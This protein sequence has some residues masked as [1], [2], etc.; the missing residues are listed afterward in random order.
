[1]TE[2][3]DF[4]I[5]NI[6]RDPSGVEVSIATV[7]QAEGGVRTSNNLMMVDGIGVFRGNMSIPEL[8][9][10]EIQI[11]TSGVSAAFENEQS[12]NANGYFRDQNTRVISSAT[13][14]QQ[15]IVRSYRISLIDQS[16]T[17]GGQT[18]S[19]VDII[20]GGGWGESY[21]GSS[22]YSRTSFEYDKVAFE[23]VG[24]GIEFSS[25]IEFY[26]PQYE[27]EKGLDVRTDFRK[28]I[29]W[30]PSVQTDENGTAIIQYYN[31]DE[32]TTFRAI[33]EGGTSKGLLGRVEHTYGVERPFSLSTRI[34][35]VLS[36]W[37]TLEMPILL[38]NTSNQDIEGVLSI[39][40]PKALSLLGALPTSIQVLK[41]SSKVIYVK[42]L[43]NNKT[44][45]D[46][47]K[48]TFKSKGLTDVVIQPIE[49]ISK[50]FP[51]SFTLSGNEK[52]VQDTFI[53]PPYH[54]GS[55]D[56]E[57]KIYSTILDDL[58]GGAEGILRS[59]WG[60]FEQ[61]S[62]AN[63]PNILA[64][65]ILKEKGT[66]RPEI[67]NKASKYLKIGYEK[68]K[69]Y[70]I[71]TGGFEWY[72]IAPAHEGLTAYGLVQLKDMQTVYADFNPAILKRTEAFLLSRRNGKGGFYHN[73]GKYGF[74]G[75][76]TALF[77]AYITWALSEVGTK[78]IELEV[79]KSVREAVKSEDL[80]R[81]SL[82]CLTL[83]NLNENARAELLLKEI[84][85]Q[86]KTVGI[87]NV[88]AESTVTYSYGNSLNIETLSFA[89]LAM[90]E[91]ST[92]DRGL[93]DSIQKYIIS[94]RKYGRFG[95]TQSTVMALKMLLKY[96]GIYART[97]A[98]GHFKVYI[99]EVLAQEYSYK[100][101][102][103]A[104]HLF[105]GFNSYF[106]L[107]KNTLRIETE[108]SI[109]PSSFELKW[110]G[111]E[112]KSNLEAPLAVKTTLQDSIT[113]VGEVI[114]MKVILTNLEDKT[115]AS[116]MAIVGI[117]AGLSL[118]I[119]QLKELQEN[120]SFAYYEIKNNQ[121][122]LYFRSME[123]KENKTLNLYLKAEV[124]GRYTAPVSSAYL[125]YMEEL[126]YWERGAEIRII[127]S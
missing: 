13:K 111:I 119:W 47:L 44:G 11:L 98:G 19:G 56:A 31:S 21:S 29:Y 106:K 15:M 82:A 14:S 123:A 77:D 58:M 92:I 104:Q 76:K 5:S 102:V 88:R 41:N 87:A 80:Y 59:P 121:L 69:G 51:N 65:Q 36:S 66:I 54:K 46:Q 97:E 83:F 25:N 81:L 103:Q 67:K 122:I 70:E 16:N 89:G 7:N 55:L 34:P 18:L 84:V 63:Y 32:V 109:R 95:S 86:I 6:H 101:G 52:T 8:E 107:G 27:A 94:K 35:A 50:G 37:D 93:M 40:S 61:V 74:R 10:E 126:K 79:E 38:K 108:G 39:E 28:T 112:P 1:M 125:Y 23:Q 73:V 100:K 64:L 62:S 22:D 24:K 43:V 12:L 45:I 60:C 124:S 113:K 96:Q 30:N 90:M 17:M 72:G 57:F 3:E 127:K 71:R 68:I 91:S 114:S 78:G 117:P 110:M 75:N 4:S 26:V 33:V 9:I 115:Q 2:K 120:G 116:P 42:S 53:I 105:T 85:Q 118:Q 99:N 20:P 48:I 49:V